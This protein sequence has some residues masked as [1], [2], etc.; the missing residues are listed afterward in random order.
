MIHSGV[1]GFASSPIV[2]ED[3]LRRH[4]TVQLATLRFTEFRFRPSVQITDTEVQ[5][6][7][8]K[9]MG[10]KPGAPDVKEVREKI[11]QLLTEERVNQLLDRWL[12]D[13]RNQTRVEFRE[14]SF[15]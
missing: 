7:Y 6:Y 4:L 5:E 15:Q 12:R 3:E 8:D 10:G 9:N 11:G 1:W 2:T 14:E 13:T